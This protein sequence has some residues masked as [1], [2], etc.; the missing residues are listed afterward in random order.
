MSD[1]LKEY[2]AKR[3]FDKTSEPKDGSNTLLEGSI[4]VIQKHDASNLHYDLRLEVNGVLKSW[5]VPKGPSL[6]PRI[7]RLAVETEDHPIGYHD[8]EG[9]I[10][11]DQYGGGT[12]MVWDKGSYR[13]LKEDLTMGEALEGGK[14][15][16]WLEG[17]KLRGGFALIKTGKPEGNSWLLL[18]MR[19]E[20]AQD[21]G[22][23]TK[24]RPSSAKTGRSLEDIAKS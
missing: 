15:T 9:V 13:N 23:V 20:Y 10:P 17:D 5:A 8:F 19:D 2:R 4:Y 12:V 1:S 6:N 24:L 11:E 16:V 22:D 3:D 18:K 7:R 14:V 21:K